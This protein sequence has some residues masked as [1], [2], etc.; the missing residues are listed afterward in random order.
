VPS[1]GEIVR[2]LLVFL[3]DRSALAYEHHRRTISGHV[4]ESVLRIRDELTTALRDLA[5]DSGATHSVRALRDACR[6]FL[7]RVG[8]ER[9]FEY[10]PEFILALGE[11]R[12]IFAIY[13]RALADTYGI[14]VHGPLAVLLHAADREAEGSSDASI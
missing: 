1:D 4:V 13:V 2:R 5:P 12:G 3:E 14:T 6:V 11:L 10:E 9:S 8:A 7:D